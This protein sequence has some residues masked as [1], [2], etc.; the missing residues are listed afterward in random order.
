MENTVALPFK[1][2]F[3][4]TFI[5]YNWPASGPRIFLTRNTWK[6]R[7]NLES[8]LHWPK[9]LICLFCVVHLAKR[10]LAKDFEQFK[11][12]WIRFLTALFHMVSDRNLLI[13]PF[14]LHKEKTAYNIC[15]LS[16]LPQGHKLIFTYT[17][18]E[19]FSLLHGLIHDLMAID[20]QANQVS[21]NEP[22]TM[23]SATKH[24]NLF[25]SESDYDCS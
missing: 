14:I 15:H 13:G 2:A 20:L 24:V 1:D 3:F 25:L 5:A 22:R 6:N 23:I 16:F 9:H 21:L 12:R 10:T 19:S 4:R 8:A 17:V 11:L 18:W 7:R